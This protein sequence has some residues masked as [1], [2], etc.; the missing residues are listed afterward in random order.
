MRL[1]PD[2]IGGRLALLLAL[3]LLAANAVALVLLSLERDRLGRAA[4]VEAALERAAG[5][6]PLLES[7]EARER[8]RAVR[9]AERPG[10]DFA[11]SDRPRVIRTDST[12]VARRLAQRVGSELDGRDVRV[13]VARDQGGRGGEERHGQRLDVSIGLRVDGGPSWLNASLRAPPSGRTGGGVPALLVIVGLSLAAVLGVAL[14]YVRRLVRPLRDLAGA[15]RAAG[16]GDRSVR[17][18]ETGARELREAAGA[19]NAMQGAI[20]RFEAER[21]R[22]LAAV[23]HDLR[24]PITSLRIRAEMLDDEQRK[25][26]V[27][28]LDEMRVMAD[29]LVAV[30]RGEG[31]GEARERIDLPAFLERLC[32]ERGASWRGG[33]AVAAEVRPVA[34]AR[35]VGNL[36]DNAIRYAGTAAVSL[37]AEA[38]D[39]VIAVEDDGPGVPPERLRTVLEPFVRGEASRSAETGGAG[40]GLAIARAIAREHGGDL[41]LANRAGGG[42][43]AELR[44]PRRAPA[45]G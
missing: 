16:R 2:S 18:A 15:A 37:A 36:I 17:V 42:L 10:I 43:R 9:R 4:R 32:A 13:A 7:L 41:V 5:F 30:A 20:A 39:A 24:T 38:D 34:L 12:V 31:D 26:M 23:G 35:A 11:L 25:P 45:G 33:P 3:A 22:T 44:L 6:V 29:G 21:T 28:T 8:Q 1:V 27:R 14:L 19:F 40:L